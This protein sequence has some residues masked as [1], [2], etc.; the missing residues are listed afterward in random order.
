MC[1]KKLSNYS[2][3]DATYLL[4]PRL[5]VHVAFLRKHINSRVKA[6]NRQDLLNTGFLQWLPRLCSFWVVQIGKRVSIT[7]HP[8]GQAVT[9]IY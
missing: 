3:L 9:S 4:K 7:V 5:T 6:L 1:L 8:E 2:Y